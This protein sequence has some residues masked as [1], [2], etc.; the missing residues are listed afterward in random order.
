MLIETLKQFSFENAASIE[1]VEYTP[2]QVDDL[3]KGIKYVLSV[4]LVDGPQKNVDLFR[5]KKYTMFEACFPWLY[6]PVLGSYVENLL[7]ELVSPEGNET[8]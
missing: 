6:H 4:L 7:Y 1:K 5:F 2:Q 8:L 3:K